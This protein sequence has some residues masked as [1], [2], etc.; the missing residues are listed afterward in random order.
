MDLLKR[1]LS[2]N[3]EFEDDKQGLES[4]SKKIKNIYL[5]QTFSTSLDVRS[6]Y[7]NHQLH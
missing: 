7:G 5:M 4:N 3:L 2:L 1:K 6:I